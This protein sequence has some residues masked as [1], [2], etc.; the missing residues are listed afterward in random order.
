MEVKKSLDSS[1]ILYREKSVVVAFGQGRYQCLSDLV[2]NL[3][4]KNKVLTAARYTF[5]FNH[6]SKIVPDARK[7]GLRC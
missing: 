2:F 5:F 6:F 3:T 7:E 4:L 1:E